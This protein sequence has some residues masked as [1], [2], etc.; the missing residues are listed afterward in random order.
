MEWPPGMTE[1]G[2]IDEETRRRMCLRLLK[3]IYGNVDAA[4]RFYK[5]YSNYLMK[6][7]G[8]T[9][10]QADA[11]LFFLKDESGKTILITSC[12][13][14]YTLL[15]GTKEAIDTFKEQLKN[16][17]KIKEMGVMKKHLGIYYDWKEDDDGN[18]IVVA[19]MDDLI[20]EIIKVTEQHLGRTLDEKDMTARSREILEVKDEKVVD[21]KMYRTIVG[22]MMY[23]THKLI[24]EG[25]NANRELFKFFN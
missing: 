6:E 7:M 3:T 11:C 1:L 8:M 9:R 23:L 15:C 2:Q 13:V 17:F 5:A 21:K 22:K 14:D 25:M 18:A 19:T 16:R 4:L 12:H 10:S 24:I 20:G